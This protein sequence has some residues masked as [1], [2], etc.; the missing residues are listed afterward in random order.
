MK[1]VAIL[2]ATGSVGTSALQVIEAFPDRFRVVGLAAGRNVERLAAAIRR[3]HP[4][5]VSV[6]GE[7][8]LAAL[9]ALL[10]P[11]ERARVALA[12]GLEGA[13]AVAGHGAADL[14]LTAMVG[15]VGL[16]PTLTAIRRGVAVAIAN[17]EPLVAAGA[18]CTA[19]A[20]RCGAT[21]LPV[22]SEHSAIFQCLRGQRADEVR[23]LLLTCSGGPF[24]RHGALDD[25]TVAQALSHPTWSM[26]P[27][28]TVDSATLMNKGLEVIEARWLF[29][30]P[31]ARIDVVVHPES[32]VH[33]MIELVDGAV[34]AQLGTPDMR[35]PIAHALSYPDRLPLE[36]PH[37]DWSALGA[38]T[39]ETPD[40]RRFAALRLAYEAL[41]TGGTAPAVVNAAN[42]V[43][44]AAFLAGR[45][46]FV[47]IPEVIA[48]V[49][50]A[51]RPGSAMSLEEICAADLWAREQAA[52]LAR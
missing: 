40:L 6:A 16:R 49:L 44:V 42:E 50:A 25:V 22:D 47:Q 21:L 52:R 31:A 5:I 51:H 2:G 12:C 24:L 19:E 32:V 30:L 38:L 11:E 7:A 8:E 20:A 43:A 9:R 28:I 3:F 29:G 15:A 35:V 14:V 26:G 48:Q 39:F 23:R 10:A 34:L 33:S 37:L 27:K 46:R 45:I 41:E 17:K 18:L 4:E 1:G 13:E 36:V